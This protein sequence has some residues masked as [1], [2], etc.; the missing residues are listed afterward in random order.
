MNWTT[1]KID[2]YFIHIYFA[3]S[4]IRYFEEAIDRGTSLGGIYSAIKH[5]P[6]T[7]PG[8]YHLHIYKRGNQIF[9]INK[10]G[11]AHDQSHQYKIPKKV[12]VGLKQKFPDWKIPKNNFIESV[13]NLTGLALEILLD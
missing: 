11:T 6:H 8:E 5:K 12:V 13:D 4:E 3:D 7:N 2:E 10:D 9:A 1:L